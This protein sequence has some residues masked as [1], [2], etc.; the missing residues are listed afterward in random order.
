MRLENDIFKARFKQ[1]CEISFVC[2]LKNNH[3]NFVVIPEKDF[4]KEGCSLIENSKKQTLLQVSKTIK[5]V[6][7][8]YY[9]DV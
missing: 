2:S 6:F 7:Q 4:T 5:D 3:S 8:N 9:Y 1:M